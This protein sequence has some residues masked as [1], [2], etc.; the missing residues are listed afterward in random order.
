MKYCHG[1]LK[2]IWFWES[3]AEGRHV[4]C[5]PIKE[6]CKYYHIQR[7]V[8]LSAFFAAILSII[9]SVSL[10]GI[11]KPKFLDYVAIGIT[12]CIFFIANFI[13]YK[14]RE[15]EEDERGRGEEK[16]EIKNS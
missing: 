12:V 11:I 14:V 10:I 8:A 2:R 5:L 3:R 15:K 9:I 16:G 4:K 13:A 7:D 6:R 1:C